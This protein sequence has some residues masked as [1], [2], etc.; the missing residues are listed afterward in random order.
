MPPNE[1]IKTWTNRRVFFLT[2]QVLVND[3]NRGLF[4]AASVK[5][6]VIDEAHKASGNQAYC[7]VSPAHWD[8]STTPTERWTNHALW[9]PFYSSLT[10]VSKERPIKKILPSRYYQGREPFGIFSGK[11]LLFTDKG[12]SSIALRIILFYRLSVIWWHKLRISAFWRWAPHLAV[13][14]G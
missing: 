9:E 1:R 14:S 7:Q 11:F 12:L 3:L 4:P 10:S 5:C 2:P 8:E 13:I 6:L